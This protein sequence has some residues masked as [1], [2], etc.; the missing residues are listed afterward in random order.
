MEVDLNLL[1]KGRRPQIL[2]NGRQ[3]QRLALAS[4]ELGT[5]QPQ[6]VPNYSLYF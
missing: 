5:A 3:P 1:L 2:I 6:L 4:P